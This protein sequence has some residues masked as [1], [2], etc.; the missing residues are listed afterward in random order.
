MRQLGVAVAV[1]HVAGEVVP[2]LDLAEHDLGRRQA[3][4]AEA[5]QDPV[6]V[7]RLDPVQH[8]HRTARHPQVDERLLGAEAEAADGRELD[9]EAAGV[10]L[11]RERVEDGLG[12]VARAA[13]AHADA[14]PRLARQQL[15]EPGLTDLV[16]RGDVLDA[17]RHRPPSLRSLSTSRIRACSFTWPRTAWSTS[18]TGASAHWPKQATVRIVNLRSGVVRVSLSAPSLRL[19]QPEL[20][21]HPLEEGAGAARVARGAAADRDRV[22]PLRLH[23]E[24]RVEGRDAVHLRLRHARA[25]GHVLERLHREVLVAVLL[26]HLLEDAEE[27]AGAAALLRDDAVEEVLVLD[28]REHRRHAADH[29]ALQ[30]GPWP[31]G[32]EAVVARM[33]HGDRGHRR[34]RWAGGD[35]TVCTG[36]IQDP[37]A[38]RAAS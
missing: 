23:V 13:R 3:A 24:E 6:H 4:V 29:R 10:D 20:Q 34:L 2:L 27:R 18:T 11:G 22:D 31:A 17:R 36:M 7:V 21:L 35:R 8:Q 1:L 9:G 37:M 33:T 28:A 26:L 32:V 14:D 12:P 19:L 15:R 16:E 5:A 25:R 30:R 38:Q